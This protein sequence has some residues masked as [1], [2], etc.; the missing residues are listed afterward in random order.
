MKKH[1]VIYMKSVAVSSVLFLLILFVCAAI[2]LARDLA[3]E[4]IFYLSMIPVTL[5]AFAGG[6]LCGLME[7]RR[8]ILHGAL[9]QLIF[10]I[11]IGAASFIKTGRITLYL[12]IPLALC[13]VLGSLGGIC[14]V[15]LRK[16]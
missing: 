13:V 12:L 6:G 9:S 3:D 7:K 5:S 4:T 8:G 15:N 10:F 2:S 16:Q 1:I 11:H 14:A